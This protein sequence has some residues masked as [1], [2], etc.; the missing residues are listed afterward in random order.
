[1]THFDVIIIGFGKAGKTLAGDLAERGFKTALIEKDKSMYG[2]TCIN[3]AC[4]PTK[5]L[6]HDALNGWEYRAA[7][8]RKNGVI[9][10]LRD[11]NYHSIQD[12]NNAAVYDAK[13]K[14]ISDSEIE[15]EADD[16]SKEVLSADK[17]FVNTGAENIIPPIEGDI[18]SDKVYTSTTLIDEEILPEK[19]TIVGGGYIGL[20]FAVMYNA[21]GSQVSVI[22]PDDEILTDEDPEIR[23]EITKDMKESGINFM[24]GERAEKVTEED[25]SKITVTLSGGRELT[26]NAVLFA[27]GRQAKTEGLGIENTSAGLTE[28][29][30]I[31][32]N[33]H[34]QTKAENIYAMG[35]V[36]GGMQFTYTSLDDY[37][38]VKSHLF[39]DGSYT[40]GSR[41]NVHYTMFTDPPYSRA[42]MTLD[43]AKEAGY[44][45]AENSMPM[46]EHPRS[47]VNNELRGLFKAVVDTETKEILGVHLY[48]VNSEELINTVKLAMGTSIPYTVLRDQ[49]YNHPVMSEAFNNLFD[50]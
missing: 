47:H 26:S 44:Q 31:E 12:L 40:Y 9:T 14:F 21:F 48:G 42:G 32:V 46:S 23:D 45:A 2:G 43:E 36:K 16:G 20:E 13:A 3:I 28:N 24:F 25:S 7:V 10:R 1:M 15:I 39:E 6:M 35:D 17:I 50:I 38:I 29:G 22:V 30:E 27:T 41:T 4:I 49:M 8:Q 11:K 5:T 33:K 34:L 19:L 37:R 18:N